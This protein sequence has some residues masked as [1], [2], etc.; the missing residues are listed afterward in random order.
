MFSFTEW[1]DSSIALAGFIPICI[2]LLIA[3]FRKKLWPFDDM[4]KA[5]RDDDLF[6]Y[7]DLKR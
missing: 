2:V 6:F 1:S 3:R 7:S 5:D 4:S